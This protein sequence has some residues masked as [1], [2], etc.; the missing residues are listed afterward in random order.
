MTLVLGVEEA[1]KGCIIGNLVMC[2]LLVNEKDEQKLKEL[3]VKDSKMLTP[4]QREALFSK[5]LKIAKKHVII[6]I[7]PKEIDASVGKKHTNLNWL[8][9]QKSAEMINKLN[10]D[11]A[12]IDCPSNNI[13]A[14]KNYIYEL[15]ENKKITLICAHHADVNFPIVSA[16]SIIAKVTR[17][18][19]LEKIKQ[20]I[21]IDF[22]SGYMAD[23]RTI[24]FFEKHWNDFPDIFRHSWKP[25]KKKVNALSQGKLDSY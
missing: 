14:Y 24:A 2:G 13:S 7:T 9:A 4:L 10:P 23:P 15:L 21:G 6:Q 8:E 1:G 3:G 11:K 16:S 22:G 18:E 19:E 25:F 5:I 12:I 20:K 17:D